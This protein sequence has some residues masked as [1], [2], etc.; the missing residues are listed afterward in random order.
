MGRG[1]GSRRA[2]SV[3][4]VAD[5][6]RPGG[7]AKPPLPGSP[8]GFLD[9][10]SG[11]P[12][13]PGAREAWAAAADAGWADPR[14]L[15]RDGRRA[16]LLLD[17]AREAV[18]GRLGAR[19]DEVS[20]VAEGAL[21]RVV[22]SLLARSGAP[23]R[24]GLAGHLICSAVEHSSVLAEAD[25]VVD[26]G[27]QAEIVEVDRYARINLNAY[28]RAVA[29]EEG[30]ADALAVLQTA[31]HEVGTRQPVAEVAAACGDSGLPLLV[32]A[33][34]TLG[35]DDVPSGW[36]VLVGRAATW[37][38]PPGVDV[39]AV[40]RHLHAPPLDLPSAGLPAALAAA[41][42][43]EWADEHRVAEAARARQLTDRIRNRVM[44]DI[45]DVAVLGSDD[46]VDYLTAFSCL[47]VDGEALVLGLDREGFA[48]S[49]GSSC[50]S[51]LRRPSHVLAAMGV[52]TQGNVRIS[53]PF[54]V[55][56]ETVDGFLACLPGVVGDI[57]AMLHADDLGTRD[58]GPA[59]EGA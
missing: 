36:A 52:L 43:L 31:N 58:P 14:R 34:V 37:G 1:H 54:G 8:N 35:R 23:D 51:D 7:P 56:E 4:A 12:L 9:A 18:A 46:R 6:A 42:G 59:R 33:T 55:T 3:G 17:S 24:G 16:A 50:V 39:V 15:Y 10:V 21:P 48:V 27:G 53:L 19:P 20:L 28:L 22:R 44:T 40:R 2:G 45:P 26:R 25:R 32:D 49:S 41:R 5:P 29:A 57:R 47:F 13:N 38:G 30:R 11:Q